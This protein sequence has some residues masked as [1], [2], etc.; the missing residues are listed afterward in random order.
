MGD[1][2]QTIAIKNEVKYEKLKHLIYAAYLMGQEA[3]MEGRTY[4]NPVDVYQ[5][6]ML[7]DLILKNTY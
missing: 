5:R 1:N 6:N 3:G 2:N 4:Q 7:E